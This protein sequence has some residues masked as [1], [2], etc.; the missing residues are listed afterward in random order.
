MKNTALQLFGITSAG[1][2]V[3]LK[4]SFTAAIIVDLTRPEFNPYVRIIL[5]ELLS[6]KPQ[7]YKILLD[8][9]IA[10]R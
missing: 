3:V 9:A 2:E 4:T 8:A 5:V 6:S 7:D 1:E 10:P